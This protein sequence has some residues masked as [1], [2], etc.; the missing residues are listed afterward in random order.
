MV[1]IMKINR[2]LFIECINSIEQQVKHDQKCQEAFQVILNTSFAGYY[3]NHW[4]QDSL[5]N[6]LKIAMKD[7]SRDS[8]I[9]YF[10]WE[11]DFGKKYHKKCATYK[12]GKNINLSTSGKLWD[13]LNKDLRLKP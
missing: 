6:I 1:I 4:L 13:F 3:D 11:L 2:K 5:I 7:T 8:W 10:I 12:N 9:E